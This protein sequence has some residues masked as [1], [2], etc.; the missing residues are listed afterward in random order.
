MGEQG[1]D[2]GFEIPEFLRRKV[3]VRTWSLLAIPDGMSGRGD[4]SGQRLRTALAAGWEPFAVASG[5]VWLRKQE[6][7]DRPATEPQPWEL[8]R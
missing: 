4:L 8:T 1:R 6:E 3:A 5:H 2:T 7:A